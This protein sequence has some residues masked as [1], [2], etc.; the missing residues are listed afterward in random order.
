MSELLLHVLRLAAGA[1]LLVLAFVATHRTASDPTDGA[2]LVLAVRTMAGTVQECR[3]L[4][5]TERATLAQHMQ[6]GEVCE[7]HG[8]PY[9]LELA[10]DGEPKLDR[11]YRPA[12]I[13]GDRPITVDE[14][15]VLPAG[16]RAIRI[17]FAP[18][19]A[20]DRSTDLPA[21]SLDRTVVLEHRRI[22]IASL[23]G[24]EGSFEIH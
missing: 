12:G 9:R 20:E 14:R 8:V 15:L 10:I 22:R 7:T 3:P 16:R 1:A 6:R 13:H 2:V 5:D 21:F 4:T 11:V 23:D 24:I 17:R 18:A 19:E